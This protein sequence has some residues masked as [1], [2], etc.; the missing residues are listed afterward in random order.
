MAGQRNGQLVRELLILRTLEEA[1]IGCTLSDLARQ[2][3]VTTRTIRRDLEALEEA[4]IP[5]VDELSETEGADRRRF[6][7]LDWRKEAA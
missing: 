5:L 3:G 2:T 1:R 6:R 4:G 7:V